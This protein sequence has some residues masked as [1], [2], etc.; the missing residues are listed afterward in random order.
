[1]MHQIVGI[2]LIFDGWSLVMAGLDARELSAYDRHVACSTAQSSGI[3]T[4]E[5]WRA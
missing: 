3:Q 1:M 2:D 4:L 5:P